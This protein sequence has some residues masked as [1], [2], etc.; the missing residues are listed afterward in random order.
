MG[1]TLSRPADW[2]L[3]LALLA[4]VGLGMS[5][6][7]LRHHRCRPPLA[8][9]GS[10]ACQGFRQARSVEAASPQTQ[11]I[12]EALLDVATQTIAY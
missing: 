5:G 8:C 7:S 9:Q 6:A 1:G 11:Y 10:L 12:G 2:P 4:L 3:R